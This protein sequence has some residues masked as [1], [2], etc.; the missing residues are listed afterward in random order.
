MLPVNEEERDQAKDPRISITARY[1]DKKDYVN[2][3]KAAVEELVK[4]RF[5]LRQDAEAYIESAQSLKW[6]PKPIIEYP[7]WD[8]EN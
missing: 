5:L 7:F 2:R 3:V 6:P 1:R 8:M 4:D